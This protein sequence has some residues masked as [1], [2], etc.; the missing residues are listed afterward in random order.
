MTDHDVHSEMR[1]RLHSR[2][3]RA[4]RSRLAVLES[5][6]DAAGPRSHLELMSEIG[7][8]QLERATVYRI[9]SDLSEAGLLRRMD[10]GDKVWRYELR[11]PC[12]HTIADNHAHF[13]CMD[14][15]EV[16]CLPEMELRPARGAALPE[17]LLGA[18]FQLR[19]TGRCRTCLSAPPASA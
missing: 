15:K 1:D 9:L 5:L 19:I 13:L 18:E 6:H 3:L 12:C 11:D 10:L 7:Q 8:G 16:T 2:G 4:T 17:N 14:C